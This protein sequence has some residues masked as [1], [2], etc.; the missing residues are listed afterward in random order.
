MIYSE[1]II[2]FSIGIPCSFLSLLSTSFVFCL[3][4]LNPTLRIFPFRLI[5]YLQTADFIMSLGQFLNILKVN[6]IDVSL[7]E[8]DRSFLC[9]FQAFL[10]QYGALSTIVWAIIITT[11]MIISLYKKVELYEKNLVIYGFIVPG[12]YSV[13]YTQNK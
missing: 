11:M 4:F 3:Y 7:E 9:L 1:N 2:I 8:P 12:L 5:L 13:M 10:C 6:R